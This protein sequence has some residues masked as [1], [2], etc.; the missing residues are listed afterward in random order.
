LAKKPWGGRFTGRTDEAVERFT[1]SISFDCRLMGADILG[2]A[3]HARMLGKCGIIPQDEAD[4]IVR[5]LMEV[6]DDAVS[7]KARLDPSAEDV[8]MN[9]EKLLFEKIGDV[10][11]KLHTA[12]SHIR[13]L[14]RMEL[15]E[16][17]V[18]IEDLQ[19]VILDQAEAHVKTIMP[20]FT[21]LQHAQP[22]TLGHHLMAWFW[23]LQPWISARSDR[24][25][26]REPLFP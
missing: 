19:S 9:V 11:G 25:L 1:E 16:I 14:L 3:T 26:S 10:A 5:G 15:G 8:H 17:E 7:G 4:C 22:V 24:E 6:L 2:S 12:R 20:G 23:M 18:L 21:H 13:L